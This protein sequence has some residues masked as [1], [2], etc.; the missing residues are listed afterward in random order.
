MTR[1]ANRATLSEMALVFFAQQPEEELTTLD[2]QVKF[3]PEVTTCA[4]RCSLERL[5]IVGFLHKH[6][7]RGGPTG[8]NVYSAGPRITG[9]PR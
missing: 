9:V 4:I 3:A 5:V 6:G 8:P 2:V 7:G 1:T